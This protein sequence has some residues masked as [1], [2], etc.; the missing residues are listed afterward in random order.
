MW[1]RGVFFY[2]LNNF[3]V[4][5]LLPSPQSLYKSSVNSSP[6]PHLEQHEL[7]SDITHLSAF[8]LGIFSDTIKVCKLET[9]VCVHLP[10]LHVLLHVLLVCNLQGFLYFPILMGTCPSF[11]GVSKCLFDC[12]RPIFTHTQS[13]HQDT[14]FDV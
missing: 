2:F 13:T 12:V 10:K 4:C 6:Y 8:I 1:G 3:H 7:L 14:R 5:P 11:W 9:H